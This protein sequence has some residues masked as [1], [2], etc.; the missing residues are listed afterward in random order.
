MKNI[1]LFLAVII[2]FTNCQKREVAIVQENAENSSPMTTETSADANDLITQPVSGIIIQPIQMEGKTIQET[3]ENHTFPHTLLVDQGLF[4][5]QIEGNF[6][7]SGNREIIAFY[8]Y[9]NRDSINAAFCFVCDSAEEKI[10]NVYYI[11]YMTIEF[12]E[13]N[14][15]DTGLVEFTNLGRAVTYKDR[16]IGRVGDFNGNGREELYLYARSGRNIEPNFFEFNGTEF[17]EIIKLESPDSAPI[18]S[19]DPIEKVITLSIRNYLDGQDINLIE[20]INSYRWDDTVHQYEEL[21]SET[22]KYRW[23]R[24]IREYEEIK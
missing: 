14:D 12:N 10:E 13:R 3:I 9:E 23:N 11:Y 5:F 7:D 21:T 19:I 16:I 17:K 22:K 8:K 2:L 1:F 18:T 15:E 6:T 4:A 24:T 20:D